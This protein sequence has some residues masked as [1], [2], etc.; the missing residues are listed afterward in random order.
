MPYQLGAEL[1]ARLVAL[2]QA[3]DLNTGSIDIMVGTD[4]LHYFLEINPVG[5]YG[6]INTYCNF[7]ISD[8]I[9]QKMIALHG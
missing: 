1:E 7:G 4:G 6:W 5:Q 2:M 3:V 8:A 9:A